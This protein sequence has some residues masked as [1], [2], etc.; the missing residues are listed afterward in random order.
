V[1]DLIRLHGRRLLGNRRRRGDEASEDRQDTKET[2]A[3]SFVA[4]HRKC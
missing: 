1:I 4:H 3:N 2:L